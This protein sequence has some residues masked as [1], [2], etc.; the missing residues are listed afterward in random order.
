MNTLKT[1][2]R[3]NSAFS[4]I[5]GVVLAHYS[6]EL[7][8]F[9]GVMNNNYSLDIIGLNLF[10]FALFVWYVSA[11]QL[12]NI[13]LVKLISFLDILWVFGSVVIVAFQ[14]FNLSAQG[15]FLITIVGVIIAFIA[16]K[17][18]TLKGNI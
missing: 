10:V 8:D 6:D 13:L 9:F 15:Y 7:F 11:R 18:L 3:I 17:Q 2:L 4:L 5:S 14:L 1:Y 12:H 16:Y